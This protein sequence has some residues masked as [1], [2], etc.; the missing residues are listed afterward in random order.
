[1]A[2][3]F[4]YDSN[5][6]L[7][8]T[9]D[10]G[11]FGISGGVLAFSAGNVVTNEE[12]VADQSISTAVSSFANVNASNGDA[13]RF[14]FSSDKKVDFIA[15]YMNALETHD[16]KFAKEGATG[17]QYDEITD[18]HFS[19]NMAKGWHLKEFTEVTSDNYMI[20]TYN[21]NIEYLT[22][23]IIG[24]KLAFEVNPEIGMSEVEGFNTEVNTSIGGVEY[25][26]KMGDPRTTMT[27][28]FSSVSS[29]FKN[30]LQDMEMEVQD[31]KKF[32]Y[33]EDGTTGPF[34]YVRLEGPINFKEVSYQRYSASISL[35][36]QLS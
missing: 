32:I 7:G 33:S 13:I 10:D 15:V 9:I 24:S 1:M 27:M 18:A 8:I 4:Y 11:A 17:N 35:V 5:D 14:P 21:G 28:D 19:S 34:H 6:T 20:Y 2:K 36:E 12:R 16:L 31:Y 30:S 22:E 3:T 25:A 26:V 23:T 29:T